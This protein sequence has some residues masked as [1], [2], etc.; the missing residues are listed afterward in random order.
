MLTEAQADLA[1]KKG[2]AVGI[3]VDEKTRKAFPDVYPHPYRERW[4][5]PA[6]FAFIT[7]LAKSNDPVAIATLRVLAN[8]S[9][10]GKK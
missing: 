4:S 10:K 9:P 8:V 1:R 2:W 3:C 5:R 7:K 6:L